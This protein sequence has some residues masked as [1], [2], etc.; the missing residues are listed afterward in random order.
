[1]M[2]RSAYQTFDYVIRRPNALSTALKSRL[3]GLTFGET[4]LSAIPRFSW[5]PEASDVR[6]LCEAPR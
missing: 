6:W 5:S 2:P 4:P 3:R 1:M